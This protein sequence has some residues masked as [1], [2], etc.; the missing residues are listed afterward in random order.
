MFSEALPDHARSNAYK[1]KSEPRAS[2]PNA[3]KKDV[4]Y[5]NKCD[6]SEL[7]I[8]VCFTFVFF[9]VI[10]LNKFAEFSHRNVLLGNEQEIKLIDRFNNQLAFL[11]FDVCS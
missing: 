9:F 11:D 1:K 8:F 6:Y 4:E 2:I 10:M 5:K 7:F 3:L